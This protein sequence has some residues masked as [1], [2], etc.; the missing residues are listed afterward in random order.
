MADHADPEERKII[1]R[2]HR[3]QLLVIGAITGAMGA[4]PTLLWLGGALSVIFFPVLAA[5]AIWLYV[6]VFIFSG[7]WFQHYCMDALTQYRAEQAAAEKAQTPAETVIALPASDSNQ[8][9][10]T[11]TSHP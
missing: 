7:L 3:W 1:L 11:P 4:A 8:A 2:I 5:G 6:L 9:D 10:N